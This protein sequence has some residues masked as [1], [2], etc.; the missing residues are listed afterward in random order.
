MRWHTDRPIPPLR[1]TT[2]TRPVAPVN[3]DR[4]DRPARAA[5]AKATAYFRKKIRARLHKA[6]AQIESKQAQADP[7]D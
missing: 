7:T 5:Y 4:M 6:D 2:A 1:H 3:M